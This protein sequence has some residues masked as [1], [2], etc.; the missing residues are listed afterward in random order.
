M[1][2]DWTITL[3]NIV[4]IAGIGG[5]GLL[6]LSRLMSTIKLL[7]YRLEHMEKMI[8]MHGTR[9]DG[10]TGALV[11]LARQEERL[12]SLSQRIE[13][14]RK[15]TDRGSNPTALRLSDEDMRARFKPE[16]ELP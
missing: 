4:E 11:T 5:G 14:M 2:V 12:T 9:L 6:F 8:D 3:G 16:K 15:E 1:I 10:I 7:A 13:A